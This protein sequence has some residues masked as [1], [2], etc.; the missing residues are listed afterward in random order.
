MAGSMLVIGVGNSYRSDDGA[1]LLAMRMLKEQ[2]LPGGVRC[3]ESDG[4]GAWLLD[5]WGQAERTILVDAVSSGAPP[6]TLHLLDP[7]STQITSAE[8]AFCSSHAFG[9]WEAIQL[10]R[11]LN[12]LPS[13]LFIYGIEGANFSA[14]TTLSPTV[15]RGVHEAV[16]LIRRDIQI[17]VI[18]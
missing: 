6:G 7:C 16:E 18:E 10:A 9:V 13:A 12:R 15:E 11:A 5:I 14:G 2:P 4:D 8:L 17:H 3:L 1:G